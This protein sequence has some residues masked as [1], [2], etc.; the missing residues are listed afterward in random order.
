MTFGISLPEITAA[1]TRRSLSRSLVLALVFG[2]SAQASPLWADQSGTPTARGT[3]AAAA[4]VI[5]PVTTFTLDNGMQ[6]VV[7]EDHRAPVVQHMV[8]Y[9]VGSADEMPG[10]GGLAHFLE[11]LMFK[12]TDTLAPGELS[13]VVARNGGQDNAFTSYDYTAYFQRVAADRLE[14]M[15]QMESDRMRNLRLP[16]DAVATERQ[17]ILEERN[18]RTDND[19]SALFREQMRAMQY[20]NHRYGQPIIGWRH[21][22]EGLTREDALAFYKLHYAPN[23]AVLVVTGDV[24]PDEVRA[25]AETTYGVIPANPELPEHR[26]RSVEPPQTAARRLSFR[27]PRVAQPYMQRSYLA[28]ER[29]PGAQEQA[30]ALFLLAQLLGG[31]NT[32]YLANALQFDQQ[33]AVFTGAYYSGT[34]LD[35]STFDFVVVPAE[36]VT[37]EQAEAAMDQSVAQFLEAGVDEAQ[38]ARIKLQLRASEIY[39]RDDVDR[40]GNRYGR[41]LTSGLTIEDVQDW[42]RVLQS[43]TG[44]EIIAVA[45]SVLRPEV[46]VTGYLMRQDEEAPQ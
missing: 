12:G 10:K 25:L 29:N 40:I 8:W 1:V 42:S 32:S 2:L 17:V 19:P 26:N 30:A 44:D 41:A 4:A 45:R 9:R 27:D 15:M 37:L 21:E 46:S 20:L 14:L 13:A 23:N 11:H 16:E 43:I 34:S 38:L 18:Q 5:D 35:S 36:G 31:G 3:T 7:V 6:V 24:T 22:M 39:E 33:V 28:P